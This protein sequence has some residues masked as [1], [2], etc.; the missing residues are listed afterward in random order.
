MTTGCAPA[1]SPWVNES[2]PPGFVEGTRVLAQATRGYTRQEIL[3]GSRDGVVTA[4]WQ[5]KLVSV[6]IPDADITDGSEILAQTYCYGASGSSGCN[7]EGL[8]MAHVAPELRSTLDFYYTPE[9]PEGGQ[10]GDLVEIELRRTPSGML[11][12]FVVAVYRDQDDLRDCRWKHLVTGG[13]GAAMGALL[14]GG[15]P[16]GHWVECDGLA[17]EGWIERAVPGAAPI[18]P[19]SGRDADNYV[20][21]WIKLPS[22][23]PSH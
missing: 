1:F 3:T 23:A 13:A 21:E 14:G 7:R 12:G 15:S 20:R 17:A 6:G 4:T 18:T 22:T 10:E 5:E 2:A 9:H 8:Y 16:V 19:L 11:V